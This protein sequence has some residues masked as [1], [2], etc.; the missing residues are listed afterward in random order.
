VEKQGENEKVERERPA[1]VM[2]REGARE[3]EKEGKG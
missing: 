2:W 3:K 1:M